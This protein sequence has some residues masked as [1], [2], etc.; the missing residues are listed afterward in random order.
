VAGHA[1]EARF[2]LRSLNIVMAGLDPAMN[3]FLLSLSTTWMP[4]AGPGMMRRKQ[5]AGSNPGLFYLS[6]RGARSANP[7]SIT[8]MVNMNSGSAPRGASRNDDLMGAP[9][10]LFGRVIVR[11][12]GRSS[13]PRPFDSIADVGDYWMPAFA[14]MTVSYCAASSASSSAG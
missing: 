6:F 12:G 5:K 9:F 10:L 7:E 2:E 14:G 1:P 11:E 13:T 3:D 8:T 4:G